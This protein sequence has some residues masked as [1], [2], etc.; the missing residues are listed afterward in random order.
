MDREFFEE[1]LRTAPPTDRAKAQRIFAAT[2]RK[3]LLSLEL[4][5]PNYVSRTWHIEWL[6]AS[7]GNKEKTL[8][9]L[10]RVVQLS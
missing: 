1:L 8:E 2:G 4:D 3:G 10:N 5:D 7:L 9:Y 6:S